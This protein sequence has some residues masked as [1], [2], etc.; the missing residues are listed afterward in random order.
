[1]IT[2]WQFIDLCIRQHSICEMECKYDLGWSSKRGWFLRAVIIEGAERCELTI[3]EDGTVKNET[4]DAIQAPLADAI[5]GAAAV[6]F[7]KDRDALIA[8]YGLEDAK[9]DRPSAPIFGV[10]FRGGKYA[11]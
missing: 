10:G 3:S 2:D 1:M 5:W 4:G 6:Q 7:E 8:R 9:W 11:A